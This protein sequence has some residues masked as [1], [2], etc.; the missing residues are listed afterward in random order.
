MKNMDSC[1]PSKAGQVA[2]VT[3]YK[4]LRTARKFMGYVFNSN[5]INGFLPELINQLHFNL[6]FLLFYY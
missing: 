4:L 2:G 5:N 6:L 3:N 1:F